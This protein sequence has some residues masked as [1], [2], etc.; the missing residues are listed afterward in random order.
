[1]TDDHFDALDPVAPEAPLPPER[2]AAVAACVGLPLNDVG[3]GRRFAI[4]FGADCLWVPRVGWH[5]W[6]GARWAPD[7]DKIAV[8]SLAQGLGPLIAAE[9][10]QLPLGDGPPPDPDE[11]R[12]IFGLAKK[13]LSD[14]LAIWRSRAVERLGH[15]RG[16]GNTKSINNA[17][18]EAQVSL[19]VPLAALDA[20]P[21]ALNVANGT[22]LFDVVDGEGISRTASVR[23]VPH[24]RARRITK[25][26]PVDWRP[27]ARAPRWTAF[28]ARVQ[29]DD[30]VRGFLQRWAGLS[31]S[32]LQVEN[33]V[34]L[35]GG[36]ANGKGTFTEILA[37][38]LGD[39]AAKAK[40]ETF[41]GRS[42]RQPGQA[43]PDIIPLVNARLVR[44][45]EPEE[46]VAL[47]EGFVKE[48]TGG[49][50]IM[51]RANYGD[52]FEFAPIFKLMIAGNSKPVI[53]GTDDG[54]WRRI[55]LVDW[56]VQIPRSERDLRFKDQLWAEASGIL[57]WCVDGL[58]AWLE[59]GLREPQPVTDATNAYRAESDPMGT[60]LSDAC[61]VTGAAAD[62]LMARDAVDA[63]NFWMAERGESE[64]RE[65]TVQKRLK[66]KAGRWRHPETGLMFDA[67][68]SRGIA[69]YS[70]VR[71]TDLFERRYRDAPRDHNGRIVRGRY[72]DQDD[73]FL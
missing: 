14:D 60:F 50:P 18:E 7:P 37:R 43:T 47:Q 8:R 32:G 31:C 17:L 72:G 53:K 15:A 68:K 45:S 26:A 2:A 64:W 21:L 57:S 56:P 30:E 70:G 73:G 4:H 23:L 67:I 33:L 49:E 44:A 5:V 39:Y 1:M 3:N 6:D 27:D 29:P 36:G 35:Y 41:T 52:S 58:I 66:E 34:Y 63:F 19:R 10:A 65:R 55:L 54:I 9:V 16:A 46:G 51:A 42:Q 13:D 20:D 38:L 71:L 22:L 24:D 59:T 11:A 61:V 12:M 40:I 25:L 62:R 28:L 69:G 48:I